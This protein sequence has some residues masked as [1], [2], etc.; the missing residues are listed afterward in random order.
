[1][2]TRPLAT[3]AL[4]TSA[5]TVLAGAPAIAAPPPAGGSTAA[6]AR[7]AADTR[8]PTPPT[9]LRSSRLTCQSVTLTWSA[10]R[11][12][13]GV[14]SYDV[15]HDGQLVTSVGGSTL[16]A[17][18]TVAQGVTWG[19]YVNARDAAGNVSQASAT[20]TVT[21]PF[22][23]VDTS[24]PST[25]TNLA[26]T[27]NGTDVRLT[28][29]AATD[30]VAVTRYD[31]LRGGT[32]VGSVTGTATNPPA[33]TFTDTGLAANTQFSYTVVARDAQGNAS[34]ASA[35]VTV[36]TGSACTSAVC[37]TTVVTTERDLP[38]GLVQLADGTVLYGRRDLFDVVAMNPDGTNK[39]SIGSVPNAAGT[40]GEGGVLGLAVASTFATDRWLYIYHTTATDNRI[41]RMRYDGTLQTSSLQVLVTGI[42]RNK[43][44]N[45]GRL[46]FGPDGMLYAA[47]GDGQTPDR[48]QD[49][50]DLAGKVL[51][52]RPDGSVPADNPFGNQV[53]S[54][55]HR[56]PQGLAFD[57]R[58]RLFEQEFGN[59]VMDET[60]IIVRG[61]NYGWP[62]CEGTVGDCANPNY[63]A[64][65]RTYPVAEASCS[66]LAIVRDVVYLACLRGNRMYR[67]VIS[68]DTLTDVQQY[69]VGTYS[70]LRTVEPTID[71]NLW[72]TT[73]TGGDKDSVPNNSNER[74]L[75]VTLGG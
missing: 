34:T 49:V 67:E 27:A 33:T 41:V 28:W 73:S 8:P 11:D 20:L 52:I 48:A 75:K 16:T 45:G 65:V 22:C 35:P 7:S 26:A 6:A 71:G 74:I 70:R 68:G 19:W 55:G 18:L 50:N 30:N 53:W 13:V 47:T 1:M 54:Y 15:Y 36:R 66:G 14:A 5:C 72:L 21:P 39:R 38:W 64:P 24:R 25:P 69:F 60:N 32:T 3:L 40:N 12:D 59:N 58:G 43:Y 46:R 10:S 23:Q 62:A 44:H 56:N 37:G 51:R 17:T 42:P 4:L 57:S 29:S 63:L 61:G 31:V 2:P 9:N